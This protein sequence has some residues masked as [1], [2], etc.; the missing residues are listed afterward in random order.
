MQNDMRKNCTI[1]N[2]NRPFEGKNTRGVRDRRRAFGSELERLQ[3]QFA[4]DHRLGPDSV[5]TPD[6][7]RAF[8]A[9]LRIVWNKWLP[10]YPFPAE[11]AA[12]G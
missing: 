7:E 4:R 2:S 5:V 6:L 10:E 8:V 1:R 3:A 11:W 12:L 9:R